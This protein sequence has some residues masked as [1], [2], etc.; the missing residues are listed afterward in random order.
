[1]KCEITGT[2]RGRTVELDSDPHLNPGERVTVVL[3]TLPGLK[4]GEG[5][6][7]SAGVLASCPEMDKFMDEIMHAR[8]QGDRNPE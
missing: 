5:I 1:M 6:R 8:K 3:Q 4:W 2:V 7:A